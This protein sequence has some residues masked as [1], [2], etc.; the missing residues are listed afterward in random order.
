MLILLI[1]DCTQFKSCL[2]WSISSILCTS[3]QRECILTAL[4]HQSQ[5]CSLSSNAQ[6]LHI[7][8]PGYD[9]S[10]SAH[11]LR[12]L[13]D[14]SRLSSH[15]LNTSSHWVM[16]SLVVGM[17]LKVVR[18]EKPRLLPSPRA[19]ITVMRKKLNAWSCKTWFLLVLFVCLLTHH[20]GIRQSVRAKTCLL[21]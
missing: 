1:I 16:C 4:T 9:I 19:V 20:E 18:A 15:L 12:Y 7:Y 8:L 13:D 3:Q 6:L 11:M 17:S 14:A 5:A 21:S 10:G 2:V